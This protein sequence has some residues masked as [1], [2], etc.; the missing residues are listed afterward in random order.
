MAVIKKSSKKLKNIDEFI[1][2][3]LK[4]I[5][6]ENG[7]IYTEHKFCKIFNTF[8]RL[9]ETN[10]FEG[11][12]NLD[13]RK[14]YYEYI[15]PNLAPK[16]INIR[17]VYKNATNKNGKFKYHP[18]ETIYSKWINNLTNNPLTIR[19]CEKL[20]L[21]YEKW[22]NLSGANRIKENNFLVLMFCFLFNFDL[23]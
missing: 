17:E 16:L 15:F 11:E 8:E 23:M 5:L 13:S 1:K 21:T 20:L 10:S 12:L 7:L 6:K 9:A 2:S 19:D 14:K 18:S 3:S 4:S 22:I